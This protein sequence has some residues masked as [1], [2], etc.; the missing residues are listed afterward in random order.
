MKRIFM[1]LVMAFMAVAMYAQKDVTTFLGIPVDGYKSAMKQ[2]LIA[3]GF[4][5]KKVANNDFLEGE[6]NGTKVRVF[7]GTNNNKVYRITLCDANTQSETDIKTRFNRLVDQFK[8]NKR[9]TAFKDYTLPESERISYEMLVNKKTYEAVFYQVPNFEKIDTMAIRKQIKDELLTKYSQEQLENPTEE[10][11]KE[12][13]SIAMQKS[14]DLIFKKPVWFSICE[15]YGEYYIAM[16]Y[17]NE[18]NH[19]NGEDL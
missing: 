13:E 1:S 7:I 18:Y 6:F 12:A 3:K 15:N 16:Y 17:D 9:Y 4:I 5:P 2:K 8:N 19:A 14:M 10:I 11:T